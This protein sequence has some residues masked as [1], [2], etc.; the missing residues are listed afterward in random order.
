MNGKN[1]IPRMI[2]L[3][4]A[5]LFV[6]AAILQYND[7]DPLIWMLFYGTAAVSSFLFYVNRLPPLL[8]VLLGIIYVIAALWVWPEKFE[9][10]LIGSGDLR[11]IEQGRE[12]LGLIILGVVMWFLAW[13]SKSKNS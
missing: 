11:N 12:A 4:F 13:Q 7:P 6:A 2:A 10:V 3:V 8:G 9:G 5:L 1:R